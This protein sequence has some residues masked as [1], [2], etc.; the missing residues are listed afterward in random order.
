MTWVVT[1]GGTP[2]SGL[3][4]SESK[5]PFSRRGCRGSSSGGLK[6]QDWWVTGTSAIVS[7]ASAWA[8]GRFY[9]RLAPNT[10]VSSCRRSAGVIGRGWE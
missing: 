9:Q 5:R 8:P 10:D 7:L 2:G 6:S 4:R 1:Q 3:G